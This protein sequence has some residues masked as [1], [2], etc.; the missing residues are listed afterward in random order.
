VS[1]EQEMKL[2]IE[3]IVPVSCPGLPV[4]SSGI[5]ISNQPVKNKIVVKYFFSNHR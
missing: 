4:F 2:A 3:I 1:H 5:C